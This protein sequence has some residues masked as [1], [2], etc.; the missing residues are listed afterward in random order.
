MPLLT[1]PPSRLKHKRINA[2]ETERLEPCDSVNDAFFR[3]LVLYH[4]WQ[5]THFKTLSRT[6]LTI[7]C[8]NKEFWV[9]Q[10]EHPIRNTALITISYIDI[11]RK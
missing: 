7:R 11:S 5:Q 3:Q 1:Q 10:H 2:I 6:S 9:G 4:E 8:S